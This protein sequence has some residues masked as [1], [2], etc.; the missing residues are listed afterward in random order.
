MFRNYW[1]TALRS[2]LRNKS[3]SFIS[4]TGLGLGISVCLLIFVVIQ[5]ELSFD[6][7]HKNKDRVYRVMTRYQ[8][9]IGGAYYTSGVPF[10]LPTV[11]KHDFPE[12]E[13]STGICSF[14]DMQVQ[15]L[16]K[17]G[18]TT[19]KFNEKKGV[20]YIEPSFFKIFD[21]PW[22][23]G[24][25][26]TALNDPTSA[27]L[28][29]ETA[30]RYFGNWQ[31]AVGQ[32]IRIDGVG[33]L[34]IT[35]I[36]A[37]IPPNTDFQFKVLLPY[38]RTGFAK[39]TDWA[40][41]FEI[42]QCYVLLPPN[43]TAATFD[44]RL[45]AFSKKYKP[46]D[47]KDVQYL[48]PLGDVHYDT[49]AADFSGKTVSRDRIRVMWLIAGFILLI[50]C[51]NF[52]NLATSQAIN[53]AKEIGVRKVLGSNRSQLKVQFLME[54]L[55]IVLFSVLLSLLIAV[56]LMNVVGKVLDIPLSF[57]L[58]FNPYMLV[59]LLAVTIVTT[60]LAGFYPSLI[61]SGF[62]PIEALK[63]KR[64]AQSGK[65]VT[66][67]KGL[68][69]FQFVIAQILIIGTIFIVKQMSYLQNTSMGFE[70]DA[71]VNVSIPSDSLSITKFGY[72]RNT[73]LGLPGVKEVSFS[74]SAPANQ[75]D[76][77]TPF[78][79]DHHAKETDFF[80]INRSID[81]SFLQT[82]H[83]ELVAGRNI[84]GIDTVK[85]FLVN[86]EVVKKL[87]FKN[88]EDV[89]N[90][91]IN[92]WNGFAK[93]NI[94]GVLKDFHSTSLKDTLAPIFMF[95][96][97]GMYHTAGIKLS[98][99]NQLAVVSSIEKLWNATFRNFA[100]E[101][102]FL[103]E[104]INDFYNTERQLAHLYQL[105]ACIAIFLSCLGLYGLTSFMAIQR[106]KEVSVRRV[107]GATQGNIVYLFSREFMLLI[108]VA[109]ILAFPLTWYFMHQWLQNYAYRIGMAWWVFILGG[110]ISVF[111]ALM[112]VSVQA[113]KAARTNPV[114][115]VR[116]E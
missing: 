98:G 10:P 94:V 58:F 50:G 28:T 44:E 13:A 7:F 26:S 106:L 109:F 81:S 17:E 66:L 57:G 100:F 45:K 39:S 19:G 11:L 35:G 14:R 92:M 101:Y 36:L 23:D 73:L 115:N 97:K 51:V 80:A 79:F 18:Q 30:E 43:L 96:F 90:K 61:L 46:A 55:M 20:Y 64:M 29:R 104:R 54:T 103:D 89:L 68:V 107:L 41:T 21:F 9:Q 34:K 32:H 22:L 77:W 8:S 47:I 1:K 12:L 16:D 2:L 86:E 71:I 75:D 76:N 74:S 83:L 113:T 25:A 52:I 62:N 48:Q 31:S 95:N 49:V 111:I 84:R 110:L 33:V 4:I 105:F 91:E 15:V 53:R 67:R 87:G 38:Y 102:Q 88:P 99:G 3:Y 65:G 93:G 59:F 108:G 85:E 82:Y 60:A 42:H 114:K 6:A 69:V 56:M 78:L 116:I 37:N 63:N 112:T 40:S 27:V 70:K 5:Y 24:S 72:I